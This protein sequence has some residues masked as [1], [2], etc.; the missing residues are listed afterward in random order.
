MTADVFISYSNENRDIADQVAEDL[1]QAGIHVFYDKELVPGEA[2]GPRL[3]QQLRTAKYILVLLSPAYVR[4][5][6]ARKELEI[7]ALSELE[8]RTRIV[9]VLIENTE[10]PAF[11][12]AK[13][14]ADLREDYGGGLA[15][16]K[17][18]L[19]TK[20]EVPE[21]SR[22]R[23]SRRVVDIVQVLVSLLG[24]AVA[25]VSMATDLVD[26]FEIVAVV[27]A[28]VASLTALIAILSARRSGRRANPLE[29]LTKDIE[30]AYIDALERSQLNPLTL[31]GSS[32]A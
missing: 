18:A 7:A 10:I 12:R 20:P 28:L 19:V 30:Q 3:E 9:P 24:S 23:R 17:E 15:L 16:L 26:R 31:R 2:W 6:W 27:V 22:A 1:R 11:L 8:G 4:S 13:R 29:V 32:N 25:S 21:V 14:Y 5:E